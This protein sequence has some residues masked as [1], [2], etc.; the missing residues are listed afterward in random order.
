MMLWFTD[1]G[2]GD[3]GGDGTGGVTV[4]V[5]CLD[6]LHVRSQKMITNGLNNWPEKNYYKGYGLYKS[7]HSR[8]YN[9]KIKISIVSWNQWNIPFIGEKLV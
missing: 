6:D 5:V 8:E 9:K 3:D 2:T 4:N 1:D 7:P